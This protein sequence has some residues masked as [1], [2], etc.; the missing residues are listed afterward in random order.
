MKLRPTSRAPGRGR[1]CLSKCPCSRSPSR[2]ADR[3]RET[4]QFPVRAR[5]PAWFLAPFPI[6]GVRKFPFGGVTLY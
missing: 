4:F 3:E 5:G 6:L 1:F 2:N